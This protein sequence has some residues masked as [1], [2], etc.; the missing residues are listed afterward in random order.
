MN[1]SLK[2][3]LE[4]FAYSLVEGGKYESIEQVMEAAVGLLAEKSQDY[5]GWIEEVRPKIQVGLD[6]LDRGEKIDGEVVIAHLQAK[7][8][9]KHQE[10]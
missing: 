1:I 7:L 8:S 6:Q 3:E 9:R 2:P 5:E 4:R 10:N